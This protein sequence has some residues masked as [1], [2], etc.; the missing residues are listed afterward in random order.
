MNAFN[1]HKKYI[2]AMVAGAVVTAVLGLAVV[3]NVLTVSDFN[4]RKQEAMSFSY[5]VMNDKLEHYIN[6]LDECNQKNKQ[7]LQAQRKHFTKHSEETYR[8]N[9]AYTKLMK[10]YNNLKLEL[11][12][13]DEVL[14]DRTLKQ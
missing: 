6:E 10:E 9:R 14:L 3:Y 7:L 4:D 1:E 2:M 8:L 12:E 5:D 13:R 11:S